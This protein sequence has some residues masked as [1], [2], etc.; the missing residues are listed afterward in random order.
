[1]SEQAKIRSAISATAALLVYTVIKLAHWPESALHTQHDEIN[2]TILINHT[3]TS[4][5]S[6]YTALWIHKLIIIIII[7][8]IITGIIIIASAMAVRGR[9][10]IN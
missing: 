8:I 9:C 4:H 5:T 2:K 3:I 6:F 7:I 10:I 1:M